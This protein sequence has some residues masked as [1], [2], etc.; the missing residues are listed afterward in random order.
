MGGSS[1]FLPLVIVLCLWLPAVISADS[2]IHGECKEPVLIPCAFFSLYRGDTAGALSLVLDGAPYGPN[3]DE[4]KV[5]L[6]MHA[7]PSSCILIISTPYVTPFA[8]VIGASRLLLL[9]HVH[10]Y[11][12]FP[13]LD[14]MARMSGS[15][16]THLI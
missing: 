2:E 15:C 7:E 1:H 12:C 16:I 13:G 10:H 5:C 11:A 4:A 14:E 6:S 9:P 3:V 8:P